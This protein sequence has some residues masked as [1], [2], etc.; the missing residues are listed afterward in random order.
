MWAV[1]A[2]AQSKLAFAHAAEKLASLKS[3]HSGQLIVC[4]EQGKA[5]QAG[6]R[7][8]QVTV[9][10]NRNSKVKTHCTKCFSTIY[11]VTAESDI[12]LGSKWHFRLMNS[13]RC[14]F[15]ATHLSGRNS[16]R[17]ELGA[18]A[19]YIR[20]MGR[21]LPARNLSATLKLY[22]SLVFFEI[23]PIVNIATD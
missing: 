9:R 5:T 4:P 10:A 12:R 11:F 22:Y 2:V 16:S 7:N 19:L 17:Y 8:I 3:V 15:S 21:T 1:V 6:G 13:R 14:R 23:T 20:L 18:T